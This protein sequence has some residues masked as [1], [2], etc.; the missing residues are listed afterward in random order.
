MTVLL[1][2][3]RENGGAGGEEGGKGHQKDCEKE[4]DAWR[5]RGRG[6]RMKED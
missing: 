2:Q 5:M 3:L 1:V 6:D 4:E